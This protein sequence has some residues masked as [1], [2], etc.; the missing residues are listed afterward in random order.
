[1]KDNDL[2]KYLP[3]E[4]TIRRVTD[5]S[6]SEENRRRTLES[7][8]LREA[9]AQREPKPTVAPI[10]GVPPAG[11]AV[12]GAA[13]GAGNRRIRPGVLLGAVLAVLAPALLVYWLLVPRGPHGP[14]EQDDADVAATPSPSASAPTSVS[15]APPT[16]SASAAPPTSVSA[17]P[18]PAPASAAPPGVPTAASSAGAPRAGAPPRPTP[19]PAA[20]P[21]RGEGPPAPAAAPTGSSP[22]ASPA[23]PSQGAPDPDDEI[24]HRPK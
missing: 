4:E 6:L 24:F 17:A 9:V 10:P 11:S 14:V 12:E 20:P 19:Q 1:M 21:R 22:A 18:P 13:P 7:P 3:T 23:R 15:T 2:S 8:R 5:R 16:A